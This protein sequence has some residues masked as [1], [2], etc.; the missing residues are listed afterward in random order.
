MDGLGLGVQV[1]VLLA[2]VAVDPLS[3]EY[4]APR[5]RSTV[6]SLRLSG[7]SLAPGTSEATSCAPALPFEPYRTWAGVVTVAPSGSLATLPVR[8]PCSRSSPETFLASPL[9]LLA[10]YT[11]TCTCDGATLRTAVAVEVGQ[12]PAC[13]VALGVEN[14]P[15]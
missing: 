1:G 15:P 11:L 9:R 3:L 14:Q 5:T 8:K 7:T 13:G 6:A 4:D 12:V 10:L 2:E